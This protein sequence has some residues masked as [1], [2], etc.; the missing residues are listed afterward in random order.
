MKHAYPVR[1][2][3]SVLIATMIVSCVGCIHIPP[4]VIE[5]IQENPTFTDAS[6]SEAGAFWRDLRIEYYRTGK[7]IYL[8]WGKIFRTDAGSGRI[9]VYSPNGETIESRAFAFSEATLDDYDADIIAGLLNPTL[10]PGWIVGDIGEPDRTT[11]VAQC[12]PAS[13]SDDELQ[14]DEMTEEERW[15]IFQMFVMFLEFII[16][17]TINT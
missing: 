7:M 5:P 9:L 8:E 11:I 15:F 10:L 14:D 12:H 6:Q 17:V 3:S 16:E 4:P 13:L 1:L 2:V